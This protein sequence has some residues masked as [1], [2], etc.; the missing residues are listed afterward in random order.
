MAIPDEPLTRGEQYLAKTAG[1]DVTLPDEPLTRMEQYLAKIAGQ[2]VAT[3]DVPQSR[4]EQYLDYIAENGGGGGDITLE[5]L[6]VSQNGTQNAPSGTAYNKVITNVPN[7]Y[8]AGDEGKVVSSGALMSQ[9]AHAQVTQNGTI[10]TTLNNS[11]EVAVPVPTLES[12]SIGANGTY[13]PEAGKAWNEVAVNVPSVFETGTVAY[14]TGTADNQMIIP[15]SAAVEAKTRYVIAIRPIK[16]WVLVDGVWTERN[17]LDF[18]GTTG[19]KSGTWNPAII[20]IVGAKQPTFP[21]GGNYRKYV[22]QARYS[23]GTDGNRAAQTFT[24]ED[25]SLKFSSLDGKV[26]VSDC[27]LTYQYDIWGWDE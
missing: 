5:T 20:M 8:A 24:Y 19:F 25:S 18:T 13:T 9:T 3:P 12:K 2:D 27:G 26:C 23:N 6:N 4:V 11:V 15:I 14:H 16:T 22:S 17:S 21:G 7:T 10:D 1:Q